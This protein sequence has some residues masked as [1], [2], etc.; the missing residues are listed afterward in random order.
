MR[1]QW[2]E[3]E[4]HARASL[5]Q[6]QRVRDVNATHAFTAH[7]VVRHWDDGQAVAILETLAE[8]IE[9]Y[10]KLFAWRVALAVTYLESGRPADALREFESLAVHDFVAIPWN[11]VC[12][13]TLCLLAELCAHFGDR[14]RASLLYE[15]LLP[16]ASHFVVVGFAS[17][18]RGSIARPLGL[19]AATLGRSDEAA[20]HFEFALHQNARVGA[21]PFV[22]QTQY[23]YARFLLRRGNA[24]DCEKAKTL[25]SQALETAARLELTRL[26]DNLVI[27]KSELLMDAVAVS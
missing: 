6:G 19:L 25:V 11:E 21:P 20:A 26:R 17:V 24:G 2:C 18:F 15:M 9:M 4:E 13:I 3:A 14:R 7:L 12:A 16:A 10:P 22:A 27:V 8:T 5:E 23:D 1:G